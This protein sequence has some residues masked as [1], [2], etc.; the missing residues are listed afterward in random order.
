MRNS[1]ASSDTA[2]TRTAGLVDGGAIGT[3]I[4]PGPGTVIGAGVGAI[5][6]AVVGWAVSKE[7]GHVLEHVG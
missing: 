7:T 1:A 3:A 4:L 2:E 6:G 5:A